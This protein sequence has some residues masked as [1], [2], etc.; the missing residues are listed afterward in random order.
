M[1]GED[2]WHRWRQRR[3]Q[4]GGE[5]SE[6]SVGL[7]QVVDV[8]DDQ[9]GRH[10]DAVELGGE[11]VEQSGPSPDRPRFQA[12]RFGSRGAAD[13]ATNGMSP[14]MTYQTAATPRSRQ[15]TLHCTTGMVWLS[16]RLFFR[17][18]HTDQW[19][20]GVGWGGPIGW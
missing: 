5:Q 17:I 18:T 6:R 16:S 7:I 10:A 14:P 20:G 11:L 19:C 12:A 3:E 9:G 13:L 15:I 4:A 8:L 1:A 2:A